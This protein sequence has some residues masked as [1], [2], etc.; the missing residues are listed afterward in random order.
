MIKWGLFQG[1]KDF[2][3]PT[4][5]SVWWNNKLKNKKYGHINR[6]KKIFIKFNIYYDK[7][8]PERGYKGN[9]LQH[10]KGL[11][12]KSTVNIILSESPLKLGIRQGYPLLPLM[13]NTI[14]LS[15]G[16]LRKQLPGPLPPQLP[17]SRCSSPL[18][19]RQSICIW[20]THI[21]PYTFIISRLLLSTVIAQCI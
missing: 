6:L 19:K 12:E 2:S 7:N 5:Q 1:W 9:I 21:L 14:H 11:Y 17:K 10:Y 3:I 13:F 4:H 20:P 18:Y 15:L 16:M 8:S